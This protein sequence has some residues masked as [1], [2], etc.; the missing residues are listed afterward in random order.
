M[1]RLIDPP[2]RIEQQRAREVRFDP[3]PDNNIGPKVDGGRPP[4]YTTPLPE[5][6]QSRWVLGQ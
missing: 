1:P 5:V 4:N 3:Y 6:S 2:G